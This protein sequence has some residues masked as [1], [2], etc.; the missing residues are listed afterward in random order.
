MGVKH[1]ETLEGDMNIGKSERDMKL[2]LLNVE[3]LSVHI[4]Y[5]HQKQA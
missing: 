2:F 5:I 4:I 3:F 1:W